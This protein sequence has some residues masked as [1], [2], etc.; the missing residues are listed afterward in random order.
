MQILVE[1]QDSHVSLIT[2]RV[3]N[4]DVPPFLAGHFGKAFLLHRKWQTTETSGLHALKNPKLKLYPLQ[5]YFCSFTC[6]RILSENGSE[7]L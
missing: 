6:I 4:H 2:Q 7:A 1:M 3:R 5:N